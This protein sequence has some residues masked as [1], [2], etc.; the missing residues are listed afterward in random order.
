MATSA[1]TRSYRHLRATRADGLQIWKDEDG[2]RRGVK[3]N[4]ESVV[5]DGISA[6]AT[7][8]EV[9]DRVEELLPPE[10]WVYR[11]Y[12]GGGPA[13]VRDAWRVRPHDE[14]GRYWQAWKEARTGKERL[15]S[16]QLFLGADRARSWIE[17]RLD[18][19]NA[20]LRGP[21]PRAG[22]PSSC[23]LPDV[24]VT[25]EERLAATTM[26][27]TLNVSFSD[28]ARAMIS[29]V[30]AL[31]LVKKTHAL[32]R[33]R[34]DRNIEIIPVTWLQEREGLSFSSQGNGASVR[35]DVL[36]DPRSLS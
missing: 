29:H 20:S 10:A 1:W 12:F 19:T 21:K 25:F 24:R 34:S 27:D 4:P 35:I 23:T 14:D 17:P 6:E 16:K 36:F 9:V 15:V 31:V 18:R 2:W 5:I 11:A 28:L 22:S 30:R 3:D 26:A 32:V 8:D 33:R 7:L 13:W